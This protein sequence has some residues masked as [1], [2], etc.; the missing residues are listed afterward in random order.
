MIPNLNAQRMSRFISKCWTQSHRS[1]TV[2]LLRCVARSRKL[3]FLGFLGVSGRIK[4][5]WGSM[6]GT[7]RAARR[8]VLQGVC[9]EGELWKA[10]K[11]T[12]EDASQPSPGGTWQH[13]AAHGSKEYERS[14]TNCTADDELPQKNRMTND[15]ENVFSARCIVSCFPK[16]RSATCE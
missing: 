16:L 10:T 8:S 4:E 11:T 3:S 5:V 7:L 15:N 12:V 13:M 2:W 9:R 1:E 14:A 6:Q